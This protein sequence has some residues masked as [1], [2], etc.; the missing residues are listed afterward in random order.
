MSKTMQPVEVK[1]LRSEA[2]HPWDTGVVYGRSHLGNR[3]DA[4]TIGGHELGNFGKMVVEERAGVR[5]ITLTFWADDIRIDG[6]PIEEYA[7]TSDRPECVPEPA[8]A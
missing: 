4:L 7:R 5:A 3:C 8:G 6:V 1:G 2:D